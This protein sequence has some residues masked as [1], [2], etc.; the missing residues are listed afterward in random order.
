MHEPVNRQ[1]RDALQEP[2]SPSAEKLS[3]WKF[4]KFD[5]K[6]AFDAVAL[7]HG[8]SLGAIVLA[9]R[10]E[11]HCNSKSARCDPG[12][13]L[14]AKEMSRCDRSV[15]RAAKE[16]ESSGWITR[17]RGDRDDKVEFTLT[18]P[19]TEPDLISDSMLSLMEQG[20]YVTD[21]ALI[22]DTQCVTSKEQG[23]RLVDGVPSTTTSESAAQPRALSMESLLKPREEEAPVTDAAPSPA[24]GTIRDAALDPTTQTEMAPD[25]KAPGATIELGEEDQSVIETPAELL[26]I[27]GLPRVTR[28]ARAHDL[29]G[30]AANAHVSQD[31]GDDAMFIDATNGFPQAV[32][33]G[34]Q[35]ARSKSGAD[36]RAQK[37]LRQGAR[38]IPQPARARGRRCRRADRAHA[39][40]SEKYH[41]VHRND[42]RALSR[43]AHRTDRSAVAQKL[44]VA[45]L[46]AVHGVGAPVRKAA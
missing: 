39:Y 5:W 45:Q 1:S 36:R 16:L 24:L 7:P 33:S 10:L 11:D 29:D 15:K 18:Y 44:P 27:T 22:S 42:Q 19:Q 40:R 14:L 3:T 31:N 41:A 30:G 4:S 13:E 25:A 17:K 9:S 20:S 46:R 12:Y 35:A 6:R 23:T 21:S 2:T 26:P 28:N 8:Y 38:P 34:P 37:I 43:G 32:A